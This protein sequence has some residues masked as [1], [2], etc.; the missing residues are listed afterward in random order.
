MDLG[1]FQE[2]SETVGVYYGSH[3]LYSQTCL[4]STLSMSGQPLRCTVHVYKDY[5]ST[6]YDVGHLFDFIV[7]RPHLWKAEVTGQL[8]PVA[9]KRIVARFSQVQTF[10]LQGGLAV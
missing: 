10:K 9:R 5:I 6:P 4:D 3:L 8:A 2:A 7:L 1:D